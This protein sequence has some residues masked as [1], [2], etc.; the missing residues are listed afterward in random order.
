[1]EAPNK[2]NTL[3]LPIRQVYFDQIIAGTKKEE[4]RE[5]KPGVTM[6]RYLIKDDSPSGYKLNPG[7]TEP[8]K[9][10]WW[11][12]WNG[13][14]Y[15]FV[16]KPYKYLY[17][18]VGYAKERDTALVEV[19]GFRFI[20]KKIRRDRNG[21]PCFCYWVMAIGLGRVVELRRKGQP[22]AYSPSHSATASV[23]ASTD[24]RNPL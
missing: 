2:R 11:D 9:K 5:V 1:M 19:T 4:Y 16:P 15:P 20:P 21:D 18:A 12:D 24:S 13:G 6:N 8:G 14:R 17:L 3:Y 10:Y 7:C 23:F 22:S